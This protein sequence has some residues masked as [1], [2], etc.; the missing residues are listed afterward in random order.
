MTSPN[1]DSVPNDP[2]A[3]AA[4]TVPVAD[5]MSPLPL[6]RLLQLAS[7]A[8]PIGAYS[9]SQ[10]L[11]RVVEDG[12]VR[13]A[14]TAQTW[15]GEV[16]QW[17]VAP[18]EAA[19]GWR[20]LV[21]AQ[22]GDWPL[23]TTWN[24]WF[25][26]SRETAELRAETEQTGGSLVK[27]LGETGL[28]DAEARNVLPGLAPVTLPAAFALAARA[29]ALPVSAALAAYVWSWLEN[30]VLAAIKLVPL[31][32]VAG[33]RLLTALGARIPQVVAI[34]T[35]LADDD[36]STFAPGLALASA[37]HETQY[38]RLFRS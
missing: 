24:A 18:G 16:L 31:G 34:A 38:T 17:V 30:Q 21:A 3:R 32:Q 20:L 29:F 25:R 6:V 13:D 14:A 26:A 19:I 15:I 33:Q 9:Y 12:I 1:A 37:R 28:L 2:E 35:T 22:A 27:L 10:G 4:A 23:L 7:P 8:L 11:E 5:A 36:L